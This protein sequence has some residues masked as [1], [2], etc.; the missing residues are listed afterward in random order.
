LIFSSVR[1]LPFSW[2]PGM[3]RDEVTISLPLAIGTLVALSTAY[4][5]RFLVSHIFGPAVFGT[6]ANASMEVPTVS[7]VTNATAVVL[8]AELCRQ[9][10]SRENPSDLPIWRSAVAKSSVVLF[11]SLGFLAFWGHETMRVFFSDRFAD[12]GSIFSIYVWIIP[13]QMIMLQPLL[14][15]RGVPHL[16]IYVRLVTFVLELLFV[17]TLGHFFGLLGI[18]FGVVLSGYVASFASMCWFTSRFSS[19]GMRTFLP[20]G[21]LAICLSVALGAGGVSWLT[22][23]VVSGKVP[24]LFRYLIGL[25]VF[26]ACY[27][28][29]MYRTRLLG[30]IVPARFLPASYREVREKVA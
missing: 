24:L 15:A 19:T 8:T 5:D 29:G 18:T 23:L 2:H 16:M 13:M 28:A 4:L 14:I 1:G 30:H 22:H 3:L 9:Q 11:A 26:L 7:M 20:W 27:C 12:S 17:L 10:P 21:V 6:Y 25:L